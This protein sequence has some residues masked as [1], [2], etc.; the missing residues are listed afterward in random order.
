MKNIFKKIRFYFQKKFHK[1]KYLRGQKKY[2]LG[3]RT[4]IAENSQ[5]RNK[6]TTVGKFTSIAGHVTIGLGTKNLSTLSLHGFQY[7][8]KDER[9]WGDLVTPLDN[10]IKGPESLPNV[11]GN[12]CWICE[13]SIIMAGLT[14]GDGAV[15]AAGAIVTKDV[16]PYAVV[17]GVPAKV[18]KYRFEKPIIDKLLELKWWDYPEDFIVRLPFENVEN[19][20]NY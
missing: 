12:D 19:V 14:I 18:I 17:A 16:P 8:H 6:K 9:L 2:N 3:K 5:I 11:I 10:V 20:L 1:T 7:T 15:V 13:R 4:Y